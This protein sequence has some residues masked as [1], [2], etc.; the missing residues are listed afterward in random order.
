MKQANITT[1][2]TIHSTNIINIQNNINKIYKTT[3]ENDK[4]ENYYS[5]FIYEDTVYHPTEYKY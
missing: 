2:K 3:Q 5:D 1:E 4:I